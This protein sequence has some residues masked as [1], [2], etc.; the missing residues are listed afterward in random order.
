MSEVTFKLQGKDYELPNY[1]SIGDYVKIFKIKDLFEDEYM[2]AKV[3][4]LLTDCP[5]ETLID[6][7]NHKV[8]FLA[9]TIFA[10]VP[11]PPYNLIDRFTLDG[12]DYGYLPSYKEITFGEFVD[13]DTL[14]TK[15]P[16]EIMDYLH[17]ICAIMYRPI[18]SEKSKHNFKIEKYNQETLNDRAELFKNKLEVKFALGGQFFFINFGKT[19]LSF[20]PLSLMGKVRREWTILKMIW[21]HRKLIWTLALNKGLDGTSSSIE[22]QKTHLKNTIKS[23]KKTLLK[24]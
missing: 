2:K 10:M 15:K 6:A 22:Y 7:E 9:T 16:D 8:D 4:N 18:V 24:S 5:M 13:L 17:I 3:V 21:T 14:L 1:L 19:Y 11:R 20:I 23:L 12:V